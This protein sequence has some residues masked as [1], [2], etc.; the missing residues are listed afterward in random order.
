M[1]TNGEKRWHRVRD[2]LHWN[3][4]YAADGKSNTSREDND[5]IEIQHRTDQ[6]DSRANVLN[7]QYLFR[8][9]IAKCSTP[10]YILF[11]YQEIMNNFS[12]SFVCFCRSFGVFL[13]T[14]VKY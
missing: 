5:R 6:F 11:S 2:T 3:Q 4:I 8:F 13:L 14:I 12:F 10:Y 1:R 7:M 9:R